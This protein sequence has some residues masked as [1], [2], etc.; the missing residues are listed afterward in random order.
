MVTFNSNSICEQAR[1]HYYGYLCGEDQAHVPTEMLAHISQCQYCQAE[2]DRL[3]SMLAG[4]ER[5][6]VESGR[7]T[8]SVV[9]TNLRLHFAYIGAFVTCETVRSFLPSLADPVLEVGVPTPITVHLDKCQQC[10]DDLEVIRQ[11]NFTHEQLCR[12]GQLF[13]DKPAEDTVGCSQARAAILAVE[14][15]DFHE[16][17][18]EVLKHLCTC[19][20][21]RK[22]LYQYRETVREGFLQA[23]KGQKKF[24]CEAVSATDIFDYCFPY[25]IAPATDQYAK[26]RPAFTSHARNCPIC[27]GKMQQLHNTVCGILERQRSGIVTCFKMATL[28]QDPPVSKPDDIYSYR[29]W[30]IEVQ[31]FDK[32]SEV[33]DAKARGSNV[34]RKAELRQYGQ[35]FPTLSLKRFIKRGAVAAAI[36]LVAIIL[37][38][39]PVAK[40]VDLS[41]IYEALAH[42]KNVCIMNFVPEK[43]KLAQEIWISQTLNIKLFKTDTQWVL[44]DLKSES[45]KAKDLSTSEVEMLKLDSEA[46]AKVQETMYLPWDM[47][48]FDDISAVPEDA[49]WQ[50]VANE[51]IMTTIPGTKVYDLV[52]TKKELIGSIVYNR[53]RGYIDTEIKL[54]RRIERWEKG[55]GE[56]KY[57]LVTVM[58]VTYP[59]AV[60][61][62][63]VI[64]DAGF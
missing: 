36:L 50:Q 29:D 45:R 22:V 18:T 20:D 51:D 63:A 43:T 52:W 24:P 31:V 49:V 60:E 14:T 58:N 59:E 11:L 12:L 53:W 32:S 41:Q 34:L 46:L 5:D 19:P 16:T 23:P 2:I 47:L 38:S 44:W 15:M 3:K 4:G 33:D 25:G 30:P 9:T 57:E 27:L 26:F 37:L 8:A 10:T 54:P 28:A 62:Q 42:V 56:G 39:V 1:T 40:A 17:N 35:K 61:I 48:P 21:C 7:R 6:A 64:E 55:S 13:A